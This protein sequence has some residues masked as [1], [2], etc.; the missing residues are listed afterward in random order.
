LLEAYMNSKPDI[1][2]DWKKNNTRSR[3][4]AIDAKYKKVMQ[5]KDRTGEGI[6]AKDRSKGIETTCTFMAY[7]NF[8]VKYTSP[9][10]PGR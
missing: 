2:Q 10:I 5:M 7:R 6:T 3:W 1:E 9:V 8:R 4:T